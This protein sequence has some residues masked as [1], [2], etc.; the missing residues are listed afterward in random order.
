M[1]SGQGT[2]HVS[3]EFHPVIVVGGAQ[4]QEIL[5]GKWVVVRGGERFCESWGFRITLHG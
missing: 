5:V 4:R 2:F 1:R 3:V